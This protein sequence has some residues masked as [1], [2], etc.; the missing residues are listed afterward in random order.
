[1]IFQLILRLV[2]PSMWAFLVMAETTEPTSAVV[3]TVTI[4]SSNKQP[5]TNFTAPNSTSHREIFN[6]GMNADSSMIQRALYVLIGISVIGVLYFLVRAVRLKKPTQRKKYGLLSNY[7]DNVE[8][9][10]MESDED[11]TVYDARTLRR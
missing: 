2:V 6:T 4:T 1:M 5:V 10:D 9:A 8:M 3:S 7:D 11:D